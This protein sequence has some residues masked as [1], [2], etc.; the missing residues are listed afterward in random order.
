MVSCYGTE[1]VM[2]FMTTLESNVLR[3]DYRGG[4]TLSFVAYWGCYQWLCVIP[5]KTL[6][7]LNHQGQQR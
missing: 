4:L 2:I 5:E 1:S 7:S 6:L 3:I